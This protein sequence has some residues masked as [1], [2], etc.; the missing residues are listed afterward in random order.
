NIIPIFN[1]LV[2]KYLD[3][4]D[5]NLLDPR[6]YY[7]NKEIWKYK[8]R[9]LAKLFFNNFNRFLNTNLANIIVQAGP[10]I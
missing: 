3:G 6:N 10:K 8:A 1:L 7:V 9:I 4:L 2:P 5:S